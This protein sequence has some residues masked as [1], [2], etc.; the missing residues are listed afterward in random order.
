MA[1]LKSLLTADEVVEIMT[2]AGW[3]VSTETVR[4]WG[5]TGRI[6]RVA[7]PA[8]PAKGRRVHFLRKDVEALLA[9]DYTPAGAA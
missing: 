2:A 9:G 1:P 6:K 5:R 4:R 8:G 3:E 7:S